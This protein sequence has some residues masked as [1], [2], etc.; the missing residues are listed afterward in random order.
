MSPR[1]TRRI[2]KLLHFNFLLRAPFGVAQDM[3]RDLRGEMPVSIL[4][5]ASL[6]HASLV[7]TPFGS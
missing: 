4:V 2:R 7:N 1:S 6:R 5:V 3:L